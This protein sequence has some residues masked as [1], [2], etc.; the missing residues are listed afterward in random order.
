MQ[1]TVPKTLLFDLDGTLI[2]SIND[3]HVAINHSLTEIQARTLSKEEVS[4]FIGKGARNM[5]MR[6][7]GAVY[8][9]PPSDQQIDELYHRYLFHMQRLN[10]QH[11][12]LLPYVY[13]AL[14][15]LQ[16]AG[17]KMAVVTNKPNI[18][19]LPLLER[20]KIS[21]FFSVILGADSVTHPKPHPDMILKAM[22]LLGAEPSRSVMIGDSMNDALAA[23]GAGIVTLLLKTGYNEGIKIEDWA[24]I[25]SPNSLI[26]DTIRELSHYLLQLQR[27]AT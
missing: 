22:D 27:G 10:G 8:P 7:L 19:I 23:Q 18:V 3:L 13:E 14:T 21:N 9:F 5:V 15:Q 20:F 17:F 2:D 4:G 6:S 25:Y 1:T 11:S 24:K 26:F 16:R 12:E